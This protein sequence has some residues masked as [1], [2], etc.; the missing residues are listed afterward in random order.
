MNGPVPTKGPLGQELTPGEIIS[1]YAR[2]AEITET[3]VL[4]AEGLATRVTRFYRGATL[5]V[6]YNMSCDWYLG[7]V[8][9]VH[10]GK[11]DKVFWQMRSEDIWEAGETTAKFNAFLD[12]VGQHLI[13]LLSEKGVK[14]QRT[15]DVE[16]NIQRFSQIAASTSRATEQLNQLNKAMQGMRPNRIIMDE[17]ADFAASGPSEDEERAAI[18]SIM[19]SVKKAE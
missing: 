5:Q 6:V 16:R 11:P 8:H 18:D 17:V 14:P 1:N 10:Q 2:N 3:E 12:R 13:R 7:T 15:P 4:L 19:Q 9:Y